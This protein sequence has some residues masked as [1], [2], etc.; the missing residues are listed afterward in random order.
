MIKHEYTDD[1]LTLG[2]PSDYMCGCPK[3]ELLGPCEHAQDAEAQR[4]AEMD[5][6][7]RWLDPDYNDG[8]EWAD[9]S[10]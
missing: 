7:D 4:A 3:G 9:E 2:L 8:I 1:N 6:L 10:E 5:T